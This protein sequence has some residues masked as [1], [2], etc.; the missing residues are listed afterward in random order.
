MTF[1]KLPPPVSDRNNEPEIED[2]GESSVENGGNDILYSFADI[3]ILI[4][5]IRETLK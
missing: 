3:Q 5:D 1:S 2:Q 4:D